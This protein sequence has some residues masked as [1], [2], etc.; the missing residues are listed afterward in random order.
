MWKR[1][2]TFVSSQI[3]VKRFSYHG[4]SIYMFKIQCGMAS[5]TIDSIMC[6]TTETSLLLAADVIV[7]EAS[8]VVPLSVLISLKGTLVNNRHGLCYYEWNRK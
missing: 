8:K 3:E 7:A 6:H 5:I 1:V 2:L 4:H